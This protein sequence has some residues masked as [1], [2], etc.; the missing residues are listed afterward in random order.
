MENPNRA[1]IEDDML[2]T[3]FDPFDASKDATQD[4]IDERLAFL[5][6]VRASSIGLEGGKPP[7]SKIFEAVFH[8]LRTE[9]SLQLIV[10]SYKLLV[11]LEKVCDVHGFPFPF[12]F[13]RLKCL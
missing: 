5:D 6:A 4:T 12:I 3:M 1:R 8:M 2:L 10:A 11:D 9:K 7:S 13:M